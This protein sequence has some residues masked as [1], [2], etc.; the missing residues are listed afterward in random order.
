MISRVIK[1][2]LLLGLA[3][4]ALAAIMWSNSRTADSGGK[5]EGTSTEAGRKDT[6]SFKIQ[7]TDDEWRKE[8]T[9]EE[10]RV[11][12]QKGT[13]P[14]F[15]GKYY[16]FH[17]NGVYTCVCCGHPLFDSKTKFESGS[18]W[19]SFYEPI[20]DSDIVELTDN[21]WMMHR[22]EIECSKC[23]AHLGHVFDD[24]PNPTGLR[25]CINS[26]ALKFVDRKAE[27]SAVKADEK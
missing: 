22:T 21:S 2:M 17:G 7:K 5:Q 23:G 3:A 16:N 14:A 9:P 25:Y 18:G 13:E 20:A 27:D 12:R 19:P 8:L 10:Y 4:F 15:T 24:G 6:M 26:A 1:S 11:T